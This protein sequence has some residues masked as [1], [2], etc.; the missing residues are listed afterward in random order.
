M[1]EQRLSPAYEGYSF[2]GLEFFKHPGLYVVVPAGILHEVMPITLGERYAVL[3][4]FHAPVVPALSCR[5][6]ELGL[7]SSGAFSLWTQPNLFCAAI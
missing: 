4:A 7:S 3:T 6:L 1:Y 5:V 2:A